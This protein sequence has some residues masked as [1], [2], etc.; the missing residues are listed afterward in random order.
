MVRARFFACT[1][2]RQ[3]IL[4]CFYDTRGYLEKYELLPCGAISQNFEKFR[5][6]ARRLTPNAVNSRPTNVSS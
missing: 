3:L 5:A 2:F 4:H 6:T 1:D